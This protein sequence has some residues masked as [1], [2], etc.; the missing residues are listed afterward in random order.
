MTTLT[1]TVLVP[2][3][4]RP[5]RLRAC[6]TALGRQTVAPTEIVVVWQGDDIPSRDAAATLARDV[7]VP[8]RIV[9]SVERGIVPAENA[10]LAAAR[11]DVVVLSD[12]DAVA[13]AGW[14]AGHLRHYARA[15]VGAVGGPVMNRRP[16][17]PS[18]PERASEPVGRLTWL[19]RPVGNMHD[20]P[21]A[22]SHR[23][24]IQVDHLPGANLSFRRRLLQAFEWHLK[25]YWQSFELDACLRIRATGH[26]IIF[27]FGNPVAHVP[28]NPTFVA[29]REGDLQVKVFNPAHNLALV[30]AKHSE[31]RLA[32]WRLLHLLLVGSTATPGLLGAAWAVGRVGRPAREAAIVAGT[33][34]AHLEGWRTGR[35]CRASCRA[36]TETAP[37]PARGGVGA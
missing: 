27:D 6:V 33:W 11:G 34:R 20:H 3:L 30:L 36:R 25:P 35:R 17:G 2:T 13:P 1:T 12:D 15:D 10:G 21:A 14:L 22:W 5:E 9:H 23:L 37:L 32:V 31:P 19:G 8:L 28:S 16:A 7:P 26:Q 18:F 29:G 4:A 24:P